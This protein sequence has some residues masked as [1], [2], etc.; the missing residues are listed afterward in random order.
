MALDRCSGRRVRKKAHGVC[1]HAVLPMIA[2]EK[3]AGFPALR[4]RDDRVIAAEI[5]RG[6]Q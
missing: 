6:H 5:S 2:H 4:D 3:S 1:G